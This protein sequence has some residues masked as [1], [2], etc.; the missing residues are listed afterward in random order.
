MLSIVC[1]AASCRVYGDLL[2]DPRMLM[3]AGAFFVRR[4]PMPSC[5][6]WVGLDIESWPD[7][8]TKGGLESPHACH[9]HDRLPS[10]T[11]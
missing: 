4:Y 5:L 11:G 10:C 3:S 9:S 7:L 1:Q 8:L 2:R 6:D